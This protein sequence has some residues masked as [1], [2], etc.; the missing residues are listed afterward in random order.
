MSLEN[1]LLLVLINII[2]I[3]VIAIYA[4]REDKAYLYSKL[5]KFY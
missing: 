1:Y 2:T 3:L 4:A 5:K